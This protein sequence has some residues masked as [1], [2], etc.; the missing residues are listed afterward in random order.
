MFVTHDGQSHLITFVLVC[1]LFC[2]SGL[3]NGMIDVLNSIFRIR[4]TFL[5]LNPALVQG[6]W[7]GGYF[8]W[9]CRPACLHGV[10][11]TAGGSCSVFGH[12]HWLCLF[13]SGHQIH[14][15]ADVDLHHVSSR[16]G[17]GR[18][19][20]YAYRNHCQSLRHHAR[21]TRCRG[22]AHQS[23]AKTRYAR[24]RATLASLPRALILSKTPHANTSNA[25]LYL[26]DLIVAGLAP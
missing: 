8:C 20:F 15:R 12:R 21:L 6:F 17:T 14:W 26:P 16:P 22:G 5:K 18:V 1:C 19:W 11:A 23:C 24:H 2:L 7:Y 13:C 9:R 4:C 10:S 25:S 3:C